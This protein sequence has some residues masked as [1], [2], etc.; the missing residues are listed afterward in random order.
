MIN[1]WLNCLNVRFPHFPDD[2]PIR[3]RAGIKPQI[4]SGNNTL[5][6]DSNITMEAWAGVLGVNTEINPKNL[7]SKLF[8]DESKKAISKLKFTQKS[9]GGGYL[10]AYPLTTDENTMPG[11]IESLIELGY[12]IEPQKI[13]ELAGYY[14]EILSQKGLDYWINNNLGVYVYV[15]FIIGTKIPPNNQNKIKKGY[16]AEVVGS[17]LDLVKQNSLLIENST[18]NIPWNEL[19]KSGVENAFSEVKSL[20]TLAEITT[21]QLKQNYINLSEIVSEDTGLSIAESEGVIGCLAIVVE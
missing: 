21:K 17:L 4:G 5:Y 11:Y 1:S 20:K 13:E 10:Q 19:L 14:P 15:D 18:Q 7:M 9:P 16:I 2:T 8:F 3:E 12:T 6:I